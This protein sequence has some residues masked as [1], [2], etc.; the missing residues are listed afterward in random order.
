M[1]T[2]YASSPARRMARR[3]MSSKS[4]S[5]VGAISSR[6][7]N[8]IASRCQTE[9]GH[10]QTAGTKITKITNSRSCSSDLSVPL[11]PHARRGA[12]HGQPDD[13]RARVPRDLL[14]IDADAIASGQ[15]G[16]GQ[17]G[18]VRASS[19]VLDREFNAR[20][21]VRDHD[22][23]LFREAIV[24]QFEVHALIATDHV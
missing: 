4:V 13:R 14:T 23:L 18:L 6:I 10:G 3:I 2:P 19:S 16:E 21:I 24:I 1:T 8:N 22:R 15:A 5:S 7:M 9:A 12:A 20:Q 17:A 11:D